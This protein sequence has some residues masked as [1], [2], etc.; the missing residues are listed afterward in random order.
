M[1]LEMFAAY[2]ANDALR[3]EHVESYMRSVMQAVQAEKAVP[4]LLIVAYLDGTTGLF[5][6]VPGTNGGLERCKEFLRD[7]LRKLE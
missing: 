6:C 5:P 1:S 7:T 2:R 4:I 3:A